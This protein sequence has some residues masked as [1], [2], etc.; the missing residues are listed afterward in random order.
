MDAWL[1]ACCFLQSMHAHTVACASRACGPSACGLL[2]MHA[3]AAAA[4]PLQPEQGSRE[5]ICALAVQLIA[6][7]APMLAEY[8]GMEIDAQVRRAWRHSSHLSTCLPACLPG[9]GLP[10]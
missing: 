10:S 6:D 8:V 2:L 9:S 4:A 5:E 7:K 3:R 1:R